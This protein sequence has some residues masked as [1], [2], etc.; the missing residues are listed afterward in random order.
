M[1]TG[2]LAELPRAEDH[3]TQPMVGQVQ[4][5]R[6]GY[7]S[8]TTKPVVLKQEEANKPKIKNPS[9]K[10][11]VLTSEQPAELEQKLSGKE[12]AQTT[13]MKKH[14]LTATLHLKQAPKKMQGSEDIST[15]IRLA[16]RQERIDQ[17]PLIGELAKLSRLHGHETQPWEGLVQPYHSGQS[18]QVISKQKSEIVP[19][20]KP[21][22]TLHLKQWIHDDGSKLVKA[23]HKQLP[24]DTGFGVVHLTKTNKQP[25]QEVALS[26]TEAFAGPLDS[27]ELAGGLDKQPLRHVQMQ[28]EQFDVVAE[29]SEQDKPSATLYLKKAAEDDTE[30]VSESQASPVAVSTNIRV[31][32]S[33]QAIEQENMAEATELA[34]KHKPG[35]IIHLKHQQPILIAAQTSTKPQVKKAKKAK[36]ANEPSL[37]I[38]TQK[39]P[40]IT[41][42]DRSKK[43]IASL[44][45]YTPKTHEALIHEGMFNEEA[46]SKIQSVPSKPKKTLVTG[47]T[48]KKNGKE[49]VLLDSKPY[50]DILASLEPTPT[51]LHQPSVG[52]GQSIKQSVVVKTERNQASLKHKPMAVLHLK[53]ETAKYDT[54]EHNQH[55]LTSDLP[56]QTTKTESRQ[57]I[58]RRYETYVNTQLY[59]GE[60]PELSKSDGHQ[61]QPWEGQVQPYHSGQSWRAVSKQNTEI[62]LVSKPTAILHLKRPIYKEYGKVPE[63][64]DKQ[65][66][67]GTGFGV[68]P[69][70]KNKKQPKA[71]VPV[72]SSSTSEAYAGPVDSL[73]LEGGLDKQ[74]LEEYVQSPEQ[75]DLA[76]EDNKQLKPSATLY[77]KKELEEGGESQAAITT[78]RLVTRQERSEHEQPV[79]SDSKRL[80]VLHLKKTKKQSNKQTALI[81][82]Q[83][84]ESEQKWSETQLDLEEHKLTATLHL[85]QAPKE[86]QD[87][88]SA[89]TPTASKLA[90]RQEQTDQQPFTGQLAKLSRLHGHE[91]QPWEGLVQPYHSG[92][93]WQVISK[94]NEAVKPK[95]KQV[96]E[97]T[98]F[99][100]LHQK[101]NKKQSKRKLQAL[102]SEAYVGH[103]E[104]PE[105]ARG[106]ENQ[107]LGDSV[108]PAEQFYMVSEYNK[109]LKPSATLYLKETS[110]DSGKSS[111]TAT[112]ELVTRQE[113]TLHEKPAASVS[114]SLGVLHLKKTKKH[115]EQ[116]VPVLSTEAYSGPTDSLELPRGSAVDQCVLLAK[117]VVD[118]TESKPTATLHLKKTTLAENIKH[119][120]S[121]EE[122]EGRNVSIVAARR[123]SSRAVNLLRL[124]KAKKSKKAESLS[125]IDQPTDLERKIAK[126]QQVP[127]R[128]VDERKPTVT[129]NLKQAR[130]EAVLEFEAQKVH[131]AS[132][133]VSITKKEKQKPAKSAAKFSRLEVERPEHSLEKQLTH[134]QD[135]ETG[136]TRTAVLHLRSQPTSKDQ[137]VVGKG[138]YKLATS[139]LKPAASDLFAGQTKKYAK[140]QVS[141]TE[142][143]KGDVSTLT[144]SKHDLQTQSLEGHVKVYH[145]GHT[146]VVSDEGKNEPQIKAQ[147]PTAV[148]YLK[149]M[150]KVPKKAKKGE[151]A[152]LQSRQIF[153]SKF[154]PAPR[155]TPP[156]TG[157]LD[158]LQPAHQLQTEPLE[159]QVQVYHSTLSKNM[160]ES[161]QGG[162][163]ND[164]GEM[165][166]LKQTASLHLRRH[167]L[168]VKMEKDH[169]KLGPK[170]VEL[171]SAEVMPSTKHSAVIHLR[172]YNPYE[173]E[174]QDIISAATQQLKTLKGKT[175]GM[176]EEAEQKEAATKP[177]AILHLKQGS[178]KSQEPA[179][180]TG[181]NL[182][183]VHYLSCSE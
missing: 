179:I 23:E 114:K 40:A 129:L 83:P 20:S 107:P 41:S 169:Q 92:Q 178:K 42:E 50:G 161:E 44:S 61:T 125:T 62:G 56:E 101:K 97:D 22:A 149:Q 37:D 87:S 63:P 43:M 132:E 72:L 26:R 172:Q 86:I 153:S 60:L 70:K 19:I 71:E 51:L 73:A 171:S 174:Q 164:D 32:T 25:K 30:L 111:A 9:E 130:K 93:S 154:K 116:E 135:G 112:I 162:V 18:W 14:K 144:Y 159:D 151:E 137:D 102:S 123:T 47:W 53:S 81:P 1:Y 99:G 82:E 76:V 128:I 121:I 131:T 139:P 146:Y 10:Q 35:A 49:D 104:S 36:K 108:Q 167:S 98:G 156:Y 96:V 168:A 124:P 109:Q 54:L 158:Q 2:E 88:E 152:D 48:K 134:E 7:F 75:V 113:R 13:G 120:Q 6:T 117:Q 29:C 68:I 180:L 16:T 182:I 126:S 163:K 15:A 170:K 38:P 79:D 141:E 65:V 74:P 94:Q 143:F 119:L 150:P 183:Q 103:L 110:E 33:Q 31:V 11:A 58:I 84:T 27:V 59:T 140:K 166:K 12:V 52:L 173:Q 5:Y 45:G 8:S 91:T 138:S 4:S 57:S 69:R 105:L 21:T 80:G 181:E 90:T 95:D 147:K 176:Q 142:T 55:V 39:S 64:E 122:K 77:L 145:A 100:V 165:A 157:P 24:A 133:A 34:K 28:S 89:G 3:L 127:T 155:N 160:A 17:Q 148:V 177:S 136:Q 66:L 46:T 175:I 78:I 67:E 115:T 106:I 85:K 118:I